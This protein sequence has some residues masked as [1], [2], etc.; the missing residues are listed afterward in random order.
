MPDDADALE[1]V[2][3][4]LEELTRQY[5]GKWIAV[6][7]SQVVA[8][9]TNLSDLLRDLAPRGLHRP[10]LTEVPEEPVVW[11]TAYADPVV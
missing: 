4:H 6:S 3:A 9:S 10:L 5:P 7:N 11:K 8:F 2:S 1:W